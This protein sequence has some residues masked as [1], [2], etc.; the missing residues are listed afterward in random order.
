[1][2]EAGGQYW[3]ILSNVKTISAAQLYQSASSSHQPSAG[4]NNKS[5]CF[6]GNG[7]V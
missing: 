5:F 4:D 1:M 2:S 6:K 3:K 7:K